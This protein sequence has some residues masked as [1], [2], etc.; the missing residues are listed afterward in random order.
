M[1]KS[2]LTEL[3]DGIVDIMGSRLVSIVLYGSV[4]RGANTEESD[5]DIALI[6]HGKLDF[7]TEDILSD[8][9]VD[10]NLKYDKV[11]SVIDIDIRHFQKWI[12]VLPFY[13]NVEREGVV[14]W[15]AA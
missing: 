14:L 3:A 4:A 2:I 9:I 15:K 6:M 13:Q 12:E 7:D 10:M 11:F 5:V 1:E 8:F